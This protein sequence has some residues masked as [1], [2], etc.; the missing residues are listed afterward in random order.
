MVQLSNQKIETD[1][2][3][4]ILA[5]SD[6]GSVVAKLVPAI[7]GGVT[8][9][10]SK[11]QLSQEEEVVGHHAIRISDSF[12]LGTPVNRHTTALIHRRG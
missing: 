11:M 9:I 2:S 1:E 10:A 4:H 3:F 8:A 12:G 5:D 7:T 6:G